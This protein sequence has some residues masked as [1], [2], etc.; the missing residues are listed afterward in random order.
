[1]STV[2]GSNHRCRLKPTAPLPNHVHLEISTACN[3][4]CVICPRTYGYHADHR[5]DDFISPEILR[6]VVN[7]SLPLA[8]AT[9]HGFGEPLLHPDFV[10]LLCCFTVRGWKIGFTTNATLLTERIAAAL[11]ENRVESLTVSLDAAS[12]ELFASLR[13]GASLDEVTANLRRLQELKWAM[14]SALPRVS[15]NMVL[16][17]RN[18]HEAPAVIRMAADL[19]GRCVALNPFAPPHP[20]LANLCWSPRENPGWLE[21][22]T[23]SAE[24]NGIGLYGVHV[25][26]ADRARRG[27]CTRVERSLYVACDG[28]V[29]PC[30]NVPHTE[31]YALGNLSQETLEKIWHGT[32]YHELRRNLDENQDINPVCSTCPERGRDGGRN[33]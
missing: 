6:E 20:S 31:R 22:V 4:N 14:N 7:S 26:P 33:E 23:G 12:P 1:M 19:G 21:E 17:R 16:T 15:M 25:A 8:S 11:V 3:L 24:V 28:G 29:Y 13:G 5:N 2:P 10:K 9:L 32:R 18:F 30:C 27:R